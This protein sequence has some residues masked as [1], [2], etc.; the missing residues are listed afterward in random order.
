MKNSKILVAGFVILAAVSHAMAEPGTMDSLKEES[1]KISSID[2]DKNAPE[3]GKILDGFYNGSAVKK[4]DA[5][6]VVRLGKDSDRTLAQAER[7][8]CNAKPAKI[9][10]IASKVPPLATAAGKTPDADNRRIPAGKSPALT[11]TETLMSQNK[12]W[13]DDLNTVSDYVVDTF[14]DRTQAKPQQGMGAV[15]G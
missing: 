8:I 7:E 11:D 3:A 6:P 1:S 5:A 12:S 15:R 10:E 2:M 14:K 9:V 13:G 4:T